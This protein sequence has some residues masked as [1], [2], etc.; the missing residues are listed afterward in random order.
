VPA[1]LGVPPVLLSLALSLALGA[2]VSLQPGTAAPGDFVLVTV[3]GVGQT[4]EGRLGHDELTFLPAARG[5]GFEALSAVRVD[6]KAGLLT[7]E[8]SG[9]DQQGHAVRIEGALE[10]SPPAFRRREITVN[11]R[12]TSPS[13]KERQRSA[14]DQVAFEAA[15]DRDYEPLRFTEDFV[16]PRPMVLTAPFGDI[17]LINGKKKSQHFGLDLDGETGDPIFAANDGDV[18]LARDCF[19]SGNTVLLH[20]GARLF[21]A[22]F[23]LSKFEVKTGDRVRKGQLL[24]LV[25]KTGRVTG[26]HL[27]WGAKVDGRWANAASLV[28]LRFQTDPIAPL[29]DDVA[30]T[31]DQPTSP[32]ASPETP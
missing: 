6:Q 2:E 13:K 26:P 11:T 7:L 22:Y 10:V 20:H 21:T 1:P 3:L 28:S 29:G 23:H 16:W 24:G 12:F 8:V 31:S 14:Q 17:R 32:V 25:G 15:F 18:V 9:R 27:H 19:A 4:P 5:P 30:A